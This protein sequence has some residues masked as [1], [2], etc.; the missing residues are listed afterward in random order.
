MIV[1]SNETD[2]IRKLIASPLYARHDAIFTND[3]AGI[4]MRKASCFSTSQSMWG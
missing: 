1:K 3:M 2:K 4:E